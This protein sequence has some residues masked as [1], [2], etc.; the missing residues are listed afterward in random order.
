MTRGKIKE[1][2]GDK[3]FNTVVVILLIIVN[4]LMLYP[5]IYV[6]SVSVSDPN[7]VIRGEVILL[8]KGFSKFAYEQI[9]TYPLFTKA[10][11]NT[12]FYASVGTV[13][14][15]LMTVL[16]A[17]PL[18][19][20]KLRSRGVISFFYVFTMFFSGGMIPTFLV[21]KNLHLL[22]KR[23]AVIIVAIL[24]AWNVIICRSFLQTIPKSLHESAYIDGA[25]DWTILFR[26]I[27]P[28]SKPVLSTIALFSIV[29]FWNDFFSAL[30]YLNDRNKYPLQMILRN[31]LINSEMIAKEPG[32][33]RDVSNSTA[34]MSL[35]T[36]SIVVTII[37]VLCVY[38]FIQKY[39][40]KGVM[41]GSIKG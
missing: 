24:G 34:T 6:L 22:D 37:P 13:L 36:A 29:G 12:I 3:T 39:F 31:I 30:L 38:P 35:K 9:L 33:V 32:A 14:T 26:I 21:V 20:E 40:V 19:M 27:L 25:N 7:S 11:L 23:M 1:S 15:L 18:S 16:A 4:I 41:I 2:I 28:L 10:Y 17:Y 8:P 5:F